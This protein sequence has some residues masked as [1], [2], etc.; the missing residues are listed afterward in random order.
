MAYEV[1]AMGD[2]ELLRQAYEGVALIAGGD[3]FA[4][5]IKIGIVAGMLFG[6]FNAVITGKLDLMP[7]ITGFLIY[8]IMFGPKTDV[9]IVDPFG[10]VPRI[11]CMEAGNPASGSPSGIHLDCDDWN[12]AGAVLKVDNVPIGIAAPMYAITQFGTSISEKFSQ[13]FSAPDMYSK[14]DGYLNALNLLAK[15]RNYDGGVS[16]SGD[17][18]MA[19]LRRALVFYY[20][21]C[22]QRRVD[23]GLASWA[24]ILNKPIASLFSLDALGSNNVN[25]DTIP[26]SLDAYKND[27]WATCASVSD[28]LREVMTPGSPFAEKLDQAL[29]ASNIVASKGAVKSAVEDV[30]KSATLS[31]QNLMITAFMRTAMLCAKE[32]VNSE[33]C[34]T[35]TQA[36]QQRNQQWAAEQT[37]FKQVARPLMSFIEMFV[38]AATP[39]MAFLVA[40]GIGAKLAVRYLQLIG[41]IALWPVTMTLCNIY[42]YNMASRELLARSVG[43]DGSAFL[44]IGGLESIFTTSND[45]VATGGLLAASVP[46]L[47]FFL[48]TGSAQAF[49][50]LAGRLQG[51]DHINE[52]IAAPDLVSPA[53]VSQGQSKYLSNPHTGNMNISGASMPE[54]T[55]SAGDEFAY[56]SARENATSANSTFGRGF[57]STKA[58]T[59]AY[60]K[61]YSYASRN[62]KGF[63][64]S[65]DHT[66]DAVQSNLK[67][68]EGS[69]R[70]GASWETAVQNAHK[71]ATAAQMAAGGDVGVFNAAF[72]QSF[73]NE[74]AKTGMVKSDDALALATRAGQTLTKSE[75]LIQKTGD[76]M[77]SEIARDRSIS[78][79][80]GLSDTNAE[81]LKHDASLANTA[82][83]KFAATS[84]RHASLSILNKVTGDQ[85][86]G[87]LKSSPAA[88]QM[89][90]HWVGQNRD[91]VEALYNSP[92]MQALQGFSNGRLVAGF[93]AMA[94]SGEAGDQKAL[95]KI[96]GSLGFGRQ[97]NG[98]P[99]ASG[100]L[101]S[102]GAMASENGIPA[103]KAQVTAAQAAHTS[104]FSG[105][106]DNLKGTVTAAGGELATPSAPAAPNAA[107]DG[108]GS[109]AAGATPVAGTPAPAGTKE[110]A[111]DKFHKEKMT[112][113]DKDEAAAKID[114]KSKVDAIFADEAKKLEE[115]HE[116]SSVLGDALGWAANNAGIITAIGAGGVVLAGAKGAAVVKSVQGFSK[117]PGVEKLLSSKAGTAALER[118]FG[119]AFISEVGSAISNGRQMT[120]DF[121]TKGGGFSGGSIAKAAAQ[122]ASRL[123]FGVAAGSA[124]LAAGYKAGELLNEHVINPL[125]EKSTGVEGNTLGGAIY[126]L[127]HR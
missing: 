96:M 81:Q 90:A 108:G 72:R 120:L 97:E 33:N 85:V 12:E 93:F 68:F 54:I 119:K 4:T 109:G 82:S 42:I 84:K 110:D 60:N 48:V 32:G 88:S 36:Q 125:V 63:A 87:L 112:Q 127:T 25:V 101:G 77:R 9:W 34:I 53:S 13:V 83:D 3:S 124:S 7:A 18:E 39:L 113:F 71:E 99:T 41:W 55:K 10:S 116:D 122:T 6:V 45:W 59:D 102:P 123:T 98:A 50:S 91:K 21:Q 52:K 43:G 62:N 69:D 73:A 31:P 114:Y 23:D 16:Q 26:L 57:S 104:R 115:K 65:L 35:V 100:P 111:V 24:A 44:S 105:F 126:D 1:I 11:Y 67:G 37:L 22:V 15:F 14:S 38:V 58:S 51:G 40:T 28:G 2:A 70:F 95:E 29:P 107:G 46:M 106:G 75:G 121:A 56:T 103:V 19:H 80:F 20:R 74:L 92:R 79:S 27:E 78:S 89:A 61:M 64:S 47:T 76:F 66:K 49:Q 118:I 8:M 117:L 5:M 94:E 86:S 30:L 17:E